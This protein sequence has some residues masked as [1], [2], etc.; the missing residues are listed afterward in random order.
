[1]LNDRGQREVSA[2]L[3]DALARLRRRRAGIREQL[4]AL[5]AEDSDL[6]KIESALTVA[7]ELTRR[8]P[9]AAG[10]SS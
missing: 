5:E 3:R 7:I 8:P 2:S 9:P 10:Q 6:A 4:G 1:M